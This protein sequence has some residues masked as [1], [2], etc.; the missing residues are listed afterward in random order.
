M[1]IIT[2]TTDWNNDDFYIGAV[3]GSIYSRVNPVTIV[4]ITHNIKPFDIS[5]AAFILNSSYKYFPKGSVHIIGV[6]TEC[7]SE[8]N[9]LAVKYMDQFFLGGDNG[10]FSLLFEDKAESIYK[11]N[12]KNEISTFPTLSVLVESACRLVQNPDLELIGEKISEYK[13]QV[14]YRPTIDKSQISGRIVYVDSFMNVITNVSKELFYRIGQERS[15]KIF[16]Q[17]NKYVISRINKKYNETSQGELLALFNSVN[18]LEIAMN[19]G[20]VAQILRL[21]VGSTIRINFYNK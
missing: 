18:Y 7:D 17:S 5:Q 4:D 1:A 13:K 6:K 12:I 3:K 21:E 9:Y 11:I 10:I 16:V 20:N 2:L 8:N 15:F 14:P 19:G